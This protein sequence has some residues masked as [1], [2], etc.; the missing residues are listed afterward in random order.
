[1]KHIPIDGATRI[2]GGPG[3]EDLH[4]KDVTFKRN[5]LELTGT[6]GMVS[7]WEPTPAELKRIARG[8]PILLKI[9]GADHPPVMIEVG[10]PKSRIIR[11]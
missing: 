1:M 11:P 9:L 10:E 7:A 2:L 4:I 8:A 5:H 6:P 3:L